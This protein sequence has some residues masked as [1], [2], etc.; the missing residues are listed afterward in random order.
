MKRRERISLAVAAALSIGG[1]A[2]NSLAATAY[3]DNF[4]R[5][6]LNPGPYVY[7]V[8]LNGTPTPPATNDGGAGIDEN[9]NG[10]QSDQN[11]LT[12]T[13]DATGNQNGNGQVF[14]T[15]PLSAYTG[16][17]PVLDNNTGSLLTWTLN[18]RQI[19]ADPSGLGNNQYG[20]AYVLG[21]T[22]DQLATAGNGYA[23]IMGNTTSTDP[24]RLI[25]YTGG[26]V[27]VGGNGADPT[28][29]I[30]SGTAN[31]GSDYW[32]VKVTYD[33]ASKTWSLFSR[34]DGSA[35]A[36]PNAGVYGP[37]SSA[38]DT[39]YTGVSLTHSG[40]YWTY[41]TTAQQTA[42]FDNLRLDL[43]PPV[44][45]GTPRD[46]VF[47]GNAAVAPNPSNV[48][49]SWEGANNW[50]HPAGATNVSW[51]SSNPDNATFGTGSGVG[52]TAVTVGSPQG[53]GKITFAANSPTYTISGSTINLFGS[54]GAGVV[55]NQSAQ[56]NSLIAVGATATWDVA[57]GATLTVGDGTNGGISA[58]GGITKT[59][60][61]TLVLA[62]PGS[63]YNGPLNINAGTVKVTAVDSNGRSGVGT[64]AVVINA[65]GTFQIDNVTMGNNGNS[66]DVVQTLRINNGGRLLGTGSSAK[67]TGDTSP[68]IET[69]AG[70]VATLATASPGDV[71]D[72]NSTVR[73]ASSGTSGA[74]VV[75]NGPGRIILS[76]GA[77][78]A[79]G[80]GNQFSGSWELQNGILQLGPHLA[81]GQG[82][83]LNALGYAPADGPNGPGRPITIT[84]GTLAGAVNTPHV[85]TISANSFRSPITLAGGA[86]GSTQNAANYAGNLTLQSNST[87]HT[88]D[89]VNG[90]A[91]GVNIVTQT[92]IALSQPV[93]GDIAWG[94]ANLTVDGTGTL[95]FNR[96][97]GAVSVTPGAAMTI[98]AGATVELN[99]SQDSL[100]NGSSAHVNV[101]NSGTLHTVLNTKNIGTLEGAGQAS[102]DFGAALVATHVRGGTTSGAGTIQ[103][104]PTTTGTAAGVSKIAFGALNVSRFDLTDNKLITTGPIGSASGGVYDG[105]QGK[106]Q[107][108]LNG[109][110]WDGL[111]IIT[112]KP[113]ALASKTSIGVATGDQVRAIGNATD[114]WAGQTITGSDVLVMYT[115]AG[116]A[117]LDGTINPDDYANISFNDN[118]PGASGYYNG[119]FNYDGDIN[120]DDFA[121]IDF[122]FNA[123]G[124]PFFTS[125][126]AEVTSLAAVPEPAACGFTGAAALVVL[127]RRRK[128]R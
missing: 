40:A 17:N 109:G 18:M 94:N 54:F 123:Q 99:G 75:V 97:Q 74:T 108:G 76:S 8:G 16:F 50:Y 29:N 3:F 80:N 122:N 125:G 32:S 4:N 89:V 19:R 124:A 51:D 13:N 84:G 78:S 26:L 73:N 105:V 1:I 111:G 70:A 6:D 14:V 66:G 61:G 128:R 127:N 121:L 37:A 10:T 113:D 104:R 83:P 59:G 95:V 120:A 45:G 2:G 93:P 36:D 34:D 119:D 5:A 77:T 67:Y 24:V 100:S 64:S 69:T 21:A 12:L 117:N 62:T 107:S 91:L 38:I 88:D 112:S 44:V 52:T 118:I 25:K 47:D 86:L 71:F 79:A 101:A 55:A 48:S 90:G 23:V 85:A 115:Y 102:V 96:T 82:E 68:A 116:D 60:L 92:T 28:R 49:G 56:I 33:P 126:P 106:V 58:G 65:G 27:S 41:S 81:G 110:T 98:N 46:L 57:S 31:V 20:A 11:L 39:T 7:T 53:V 72:I 9:F 42:K 15:T 103:I 30:A 43:A 35:F 22:S 114:L 87:I 63:T